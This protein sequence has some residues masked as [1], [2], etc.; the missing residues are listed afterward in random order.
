VAYQFGNA[1][2]TAGTGQDLDGLT[3]TLVSIEN[4]LG[5]EGDNDFVGNN[6]DNVLD[7]GWGNDTLNGRRGD[8]TLIGGEGE[9][10]FEF[11][12]NGFAN[13]QDVVQDFQL[14]VDRLD[15]S[16]SSIGDLGEF[17]D[18]ATQVGADVVIDTGNGAITLL[19]VQVGAMSFGDFIF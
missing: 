2:L 7:G 11:D 19:N 14:G 16:A 12:Q 13:D 3:D 4:L 17:Q 15:F 8:D 10:I 5:G 6:Q 1:N 9:D 18:V